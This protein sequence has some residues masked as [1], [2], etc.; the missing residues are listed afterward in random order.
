MHTSF[1]IVVAVVATFS[2]LLMRINQICYSL[3]K[4]D[5]FV[6]PFHFALRSVVCF[7][8][9]R[10][11]LLFVFLWISIDISILE[12]GLRYYSFVVIWIVHA[13]FYMHVST[14]HCDAFGIGNR[15]HFVWL[16]L[17]RR[18]N[19][20]RQ[21]IE[22]GSNKI[23]HACCSN[24]EW[25]HSNVEL[26]ARKNI[27]HKKLQFSNSRLPTYSHR[28]SSNFWC[29]NYNSHSIGHPSKLPMNSFQRQSFILPPNHIQL[30]KWKNAITKSKTRR[31]TR[32]MKQN[33]NVESGNK[34]HHTTIPWICC[35]FFVKRKDE[36]DGTI[37]H[38]NEKFFLIPK[39]QISLAT[40]TDFTYNVTMLFVLRETDTILEN[41]FISTIFSPSSS[42]FDI[43]IEKQVREWP[44]IANANDLY[45]DEMILHSSWS[46]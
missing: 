29:K 24:H 8:L 37:G 2:R 44:V 10:D 7:A 32:W 46:A 39:N 45:E 22:G 3:R 6:Y 31:R 42:H 4:I 23:V 30:I 20:F 18:A 17:Q 16:A 15:A 21:E 25:L 28:F 5:V 9:L 13:R 35:I 27:Y 36:E 19:I 41:V 12:R 40:Q 1:A 11:A 34:K 26:M 33:R 43:K 14:M 38:H